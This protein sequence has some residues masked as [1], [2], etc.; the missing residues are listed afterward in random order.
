MLRQL[1]SIHDI[2]ALSQPRTLTVV[3]V[4]KKIHLSCYSYLE[5]SF[6]MQRSLSSFHLLRDVAGCSP[7]TLAPVVDGVGQ[8]GRSA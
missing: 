2:F 1:H 4:S 7:D 6:K 5:M 3:D 8:Q